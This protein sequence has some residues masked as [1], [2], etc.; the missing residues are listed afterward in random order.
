MG[1]NWNEYGIFIGNLRKRANQG[2]KGVV[3]RIG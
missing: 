3:G 1:E 2:D